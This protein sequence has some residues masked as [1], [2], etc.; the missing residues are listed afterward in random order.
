MR[1]IKKAS[2][3]QKGITGLETAIVLIAFVVVASVFAFAVL[4]TGLVTSAKS[5]EV[6]QDALSEASGTIML[7]GDV[8]AE[9]T[10]SDGEVDK[11]F[12][13]VAT[14]GH[15]EPIDLT[16]GA[17]IIRYSDASQ[18]VMFDTPAKLLATPVGNADS[19]Y[20]L[21]QG[22][23]FELALLDLE[24]SLDPALTQGKSLLIEVMP[25]KGAVLRIGRATPV[26][27]GKYNHLTG[28]NSARQ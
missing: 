22:E 7:Q 23:M 13:L 12:L 6:H 17:T 26:R 20:L 15:G 9:D 8:T 25:P 16:P 3:D 18:S 19:D 10:D 11:I 21:E 4:S 24:T 1:R 27:I 2:D 5:D 14:A 28:G